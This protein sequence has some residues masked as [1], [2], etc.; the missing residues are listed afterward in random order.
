[1]KAF[2]FGFLAAMGFAGIVCAPILVNHTA[3]ALQEQCRNQDNSVAQTDD[4][5]DFCAKYMR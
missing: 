5:I 4:F 2:A 1:M 3:E